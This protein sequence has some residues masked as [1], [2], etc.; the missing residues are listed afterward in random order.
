MKMIVDKKLFVS[1]PSVSLYYNDAIIFT[2]L[3]QQLCQN[4]SELLI[5]QQ[6]P[7]DIKI[8][9]CKDML[10]DPQNKCSAIRLIDQCYSLFSYYFAEHK[11]LANYKQPQCNLMVCLPLVKPLVSFVRKD[12]DFT[13]IIRSCIKIQQ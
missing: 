9:F 13:V 8:N 4:I 11:L 12:M 2:P 10:F 7:I 6:I 5:K 3:F 1:I